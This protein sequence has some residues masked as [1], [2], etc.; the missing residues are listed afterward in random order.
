MTRRPRQCCPAGPRYRRV[1][2]RPR[3]LVS[4]R[5]LLRTKEGVRSSFACDLE[6]LAISRF[7]K[8]VLCETSGGRKRWSYVP[9]TIVKVTVRDAGAAIWTAGVALKR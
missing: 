8:N 5:P 9:E 3:S 7:A 1:A 2:P 6:V 4:H